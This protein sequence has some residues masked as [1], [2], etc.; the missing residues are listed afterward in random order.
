VKRPP[1]GSVLVQPVAISALVVLVVN[2]HV[3]KAWQPSWLTGKLSD[4]AGMLLA[5][6]VLVAIADA[7]V[8]R[9]LLG[10]RYV[11]ISAWLAALSVAAA[12][13]A[14]KTWEPATELYEVGLSLANLPLRWLVGAFVDLGPATAHTVLVADRTDLLALPMGFAALRIA[15]RRS[16]SV[17]LLARP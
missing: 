12:F 15:A 1:L 10:R 17:A 3:L 11:R 7:V 4:F 9:A 13:A 8:P 5:P 2:D 6:L 16:R 14:T